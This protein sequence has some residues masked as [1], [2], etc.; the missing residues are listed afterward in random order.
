MNKLK[1]KNYSNILIFIF[2][3]KIK[4]YHKIHANMLKRLRKLFIIDK[5]HSFLNYNNWLINSVVQALNYFRISI[6]LAIFL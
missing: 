2:I 6:D 1:N 4:I 5:L 3:E